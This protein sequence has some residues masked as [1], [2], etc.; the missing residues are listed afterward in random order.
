MKTKL[1]IICLAV[2]ILFAGCGDK[3]EVEEAKDVND[4]EVVQGVEAEGILDTNEP[5]DTN[6]VSTERP[7]RRPRTEFGDFR[8][9]GQRE[10]RAGR[11]IG[12]RAD[13]N[14]VA[15][16]NEV[17]ITDPNAVGV[18]P[19]ALQNLNLKNV[20]MKI[21]IQ[22]LSEL[23]GKVIIPDEASLAKKITIYAHKKVPTKKAIQMIYR[24]LRLNG[25]VIEETEDKDT[26]CIKPIEES[27]LGYVPTVEPNQP[28][29]LIENKE[30]RIQKFFDLK[31]Y[32]APQMV[33][34]LKPLVSEHGYLSSDENT[35]K[36]LVVDTVGN[37]I[38]IEKIIEQFDVP[39]A[40]QDTETEIFQ[41]KY[42]DPAEIV[43]LLNQFLSGE[44]T[45]GLR[46]STSRSSTSRGS[47]RFR[48]FGGPRSS[49]QQTRTSGTSAS[50]GTGSDV[51]ILIPE[52]KRRWIIARA[53]PENM[54]IIRKWIQKLDVE[55]D[56]DPE[57]D[58]K[59]DWEAIELT[60]ASASEVADAIKS[61]LQDR[62]EELRPIFSINALEQ[63]KKVV[64]TGDERTRALINQLIKEIDVLPPPDRILPEETIPLKYL[65]PE[66][67]VEKLK[68]IYPVTAV[69][70]AI[71]RGY[72]PFG[73][74]RGRIQAP[75]EEIYIT[76]LP[77]QDAITV[78]AESKELL[79][80]IKARVKE[81]D[82]LPVFAE[83]KP[84]TVE[85]RNTDPIEMTQ[86]LNDFF[87]GEQ[88]VSGQSVFR[89]IFGSG[90]GSEKINKLYGKVIF[91]EVPGTKK[92]LVASTIP[93]ILDD[94]VEFVKELDEAEPG[95]MP[96]VVQ[97]KYADCEDLIERLNAIFNEPGTTARIRRS[98][99]G[100]LEQTIQVEEDGAQQ[101]GQEEAP[102]EY[103]PPWSGSGAR[104]SVGEELPISNVIGKVRFIP[105]P[106]TKTIIVLAPLEYIEEIVLL[107]NELD[108]P[109]KQVMIK[110]VV[111][112]VDKS[113]LDSVGMQIASDPTAFGALGENS[114]SALSQLTHQ[115][116]HGS[117]IFGAG[118]TSGNLS[119][120]DLGMNITFLLDFL[121]KY[122]DAKVINEQVL[123]TK[124]NE[125][126]EFFKGKEI[127]LIT[128]S[129]VSG[130]GIVT[131][132]FER[133]KIGMTV[134][135][136]PNI[137]PEK[138][139]DMIMYLALSQLSQDLVNTQPVILE[140]E[141]KT[142]MIVKDCQTVLLASILTEEDSRIE[143]KI[144]LLG[145]LPLLG[146]LFRHNGSLKLNSELLVFITPTVIDEESSPEDVPEIQKALEKKESVEE[147][148]KEM[149]ELFLGEIG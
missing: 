133:K 94:I 53:S 146:G 102:G 47:D 15:D 115:Q 27:K 54:K 16:A 76:S 59:S 70:G 107:I 137:T 38:R 20:E 55:E 125:T 58:L 64:I 93:E 108:K 112:E 149:I 127:S 46:T 140:T 95:E 120:V 126:G 52:P 83:I 121:V 19:N 87:G 24:A 145:D 42:G 114:I 128:Q 6:D 40:G 135:A 100:I 89:L 41:I 98:E 14:A 44:S 62:P 31:S 110:V 75:E 123:W 84:R 1:I 74:Y 48:G 138:D 57:E 136:K 109:G 129:S 13:P 148:L 99:V 147:S 50:T 56:F 18:D 122:T 141:T 2:S 118:G 78:R 80:Q 33:E 124:D 69:S 143:R 21:I 17:V 72:S 36:L 85:L 29:A 117:M 130:Q 97:L 131:Q 103:T 111:V 63:A 10:G 25:F 65:D 49:S 45:T 8:F 134:R 32:P 22:R 67:T 5:S 71:S 77:S 90:A 92:I 88:G 91:Q 9:V 11:G 113:K 60:Y 142:N 66:E 68:E 105:D 79:E 26:I 139:V 119:A 35:N 12:R 101:Q 37:L 4:V 96:R 39:E 116:S 43:R 7:R 106:R 104:G 144:P 3:E 28:V 23:T 30:Q 86:M 82:V 51:V 61:N 132:G 81:W 73:G 34:I